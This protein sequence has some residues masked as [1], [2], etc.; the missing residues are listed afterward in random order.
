MFNKFCGLQ[1]F[2]IWLKTTEGEK[3]FGKKKVDMDEVCPVAI[4]Y[5]E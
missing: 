3:T 1:L 4:N 5:S 2:K